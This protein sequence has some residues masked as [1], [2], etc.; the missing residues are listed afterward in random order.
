MEVWD[1]LLELE[2]PSRVMLCKLETRHAYGVRSIQ[3]GNMARLYLVPE[4]LDMSI[5]GR[6]WARVHVHACKIQ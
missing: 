3:G 6:F 2:T 5:S 4:I 1:E